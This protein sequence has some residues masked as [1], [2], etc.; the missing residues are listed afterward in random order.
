MAGRDAETVEPVECDC[1][2]EMLLRS[3]GTERSIPV[4][5]DGVWFRGYVCPECGEGRRFE[6]DETA[7]EWTRTD[8]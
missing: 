8:G 5:G 7:T 6:W 4:G 2:A 3:E 1:G